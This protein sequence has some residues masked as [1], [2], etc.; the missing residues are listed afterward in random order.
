MG[1]G[2]ALD[3]LHIKA[4]CA[5]P[6]QRSGQLTRLVTRRKQQ[7]Q[8]LALPGHDRRLRAALDHDEPGRVVA[9]GVDACAEDLQTI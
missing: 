2:T 7:R 6:V 3:A 4:P 8:P 9:I 5:D 1:Q